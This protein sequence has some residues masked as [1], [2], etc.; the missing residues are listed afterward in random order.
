MRWFHGAWSGHPSSPLLVPLACA[1]LGACGGLS[2][3]PL[4]SPC[5]PD[6]MVTSGMGRSSP[7]E[8]VEMP[9]AGGPGASA[10]PHRPRPLQ[11]HHTIQNSDDAYVGLRSALPSQG[12]GLP[13]G[14]GSGCALCLCCSGPLAVGR[15]HFP[16]QVLSCSSLCPMFQQRPAAL[17]GAPEK[18]ASQAG[19]QA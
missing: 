18:V 17:T 3:L 10:A 15:T 12:W 6:A 9:A 16:C 19:R 5:S 11:R 7:G 14:R 4:F 2:V 8:A 1:S 13:G